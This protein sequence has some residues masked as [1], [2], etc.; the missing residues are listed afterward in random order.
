MYVKPGETYRRRDVLEALLVRSCNDLAMLLG[1]DN[2]GTLEAFIEKMNT[3]ADQLGMLNS[4]F[5][6]PHGLTLDGQYS[7]AS[8]MAK[9]AIEAYKQPEIRQFV[10]TKTVTF[11][12]NDG[13][14]KTLLNTNRVM[15]AQDYCNGMKTGYTRASGFC[16]VAS[17]QKD[18]L[19]RIVVILGSTS[20]S[21][22]KDAQALLEWALKA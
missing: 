20:T 21:V 9:L 7:T 11:E 14:E 13:T 10:Q 3:K 2:A 5:K 12:L 1:R 18:G 8:D 6:N 22:W 4:H 17:G 19:N 16:L 15:Q